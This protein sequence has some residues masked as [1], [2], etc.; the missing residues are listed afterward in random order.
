MGSVGRPDL[1]GD[2]ERNARELYRSL[3]QKIL[4]LPDFV[5]VYPTHFSGSVCGKGM[6]GK[7]SSTIAFEKRFN[8]LLSLSEDEF[9]ATISKDVGPKPQEMMNIITRNQGRA[10]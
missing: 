2:T 4:T 7:P 9:I 3:H 6:S 5:E 10:D 8:P 1:P